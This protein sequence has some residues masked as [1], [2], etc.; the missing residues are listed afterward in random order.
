MIV[1]FDWL[2]DYVAIDVPAEELERRL[3]M[4]GLN[5]EGTET[6]GDDLAID[7]EVTSNRPDCLGHLGVAREAAVLLGKPLKL[8]PVELT[9]HAQPA[10]KLTS[11][12]IDCPELCYRYIARVIRGVK[13]GPSPPWLKRRLATLEIGDINNIV[14]ITNYVLM[15][16]GQPLHAFDLAKLT[17]RQ[18]IV[19]D[20]RAG[21]PFRAINHKSYELTPGMCVIADHQRPVALGGVMGGADSEVSQKTVDLLIES[22]EF[23]PVSIRNT[24]RALNLR[25]DSSHR[26]ERGVDPAG[27]EWASRRCCQL[28]LESAGGEL[29]AGS[30]DVGRRPP[31]R[32]PIVLRLDQLA[33]VL[34]IEIDRQRVREILAALGNR[35]VR[36]DEKRVEV[37]P[38]SWR[39]DLT[40]EIDLVE[41]VAR[42]HGY[43]DIPE[44]VSVPM[45]KSARRD[46]DRVLE[47]VRHVLS[48]AGLDEA[49][50]LS[51]V[52][53]DAVK[54]FSPWTDR[55]A[56]K[57]ETPILR[58]ADHLRQSLIPSLLAVRKTNEGLSNLDIELYEIAKIYLPNGDDL[59]EEWWMLGLTTGGDYSH[60]KGV[61]EAIVSDLMP[62][63]ALDVDSLSDELLTDGRGARLRVGGELFGFIG[64]VSQQGL[65]R[66][67]LRGPTTVAEIK[68][69]ALFAGAT[70]I[71][72]Y[73]PPANFPAIQRDLNLEVDESVRW[74]DVAANVRQAGGDLLEAVEYQDTYCDPQRLEKGKKRLLLRL[75]FRWAEG[76]LTNQEADDLRDR[77]VAA[78][79]GQ[80][81]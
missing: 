10:E 29:A 73:T 26:F 36:A 19:R 75:R 44:D 23:S 56:L 37:I 72:Q 22:A 38:P 31:E 70:L 8:P 66:F 2:K 20:A 61:I 53:E 33:R 68:L 62:G 81:R 64:E 3:M 34:G 60:A 58:G 48:A 13:I 76:T 54:A 63:A 16:C 57:S 4:A 5:H 42:I 39:Q 14:D 80:L 77:I 6:V 49:Y 67:A 59:P 17:G 47:R 43:E 12:R 11:V 27:V 65:E 55:P 32:E 41:E 40:R 78:T 28:I 52:D 1:S 50:T 79:G 69:S 30:V 45:S 46:D 7:L 9:E 35:E 15:E 24:S 74:A 51:A 21:E 18:I 25:S 71:P